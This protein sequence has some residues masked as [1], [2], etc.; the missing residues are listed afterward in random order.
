MNAGQKLSDLLDRTKE[1][2]EDD[3][4]L[5]VHAV[6]SFIVSE[7]FCDY[8]RSDDDFQ[9]NRKTQFVDAVREKINALRELDPHL[10]DQVDV[11]CAEFEC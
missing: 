10:A 3:Y 7:E 2:V 4:Q 9:E 5:A 6:F 1:K 8:M 11:W